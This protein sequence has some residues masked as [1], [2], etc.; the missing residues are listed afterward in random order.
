M[1]GFM[2]AP[3]ILKLLIIILVISLFTQPKEASAISIGSNLRNAPNAFWG[4]ELAPIFNPI[5]GQPQLAA[6]G[7]T[8]CTFRNAGYMGSLQ[9]GSFV[10]SNGFITEVRVR[11]GSNPA[12]LRVVIMQCSPGLCGTAVRFSRVFRPK[13]NGITVFQTLLKVSRSSTTGNN[14]LQNITD[15]VGISAVGPGTLPLRDEGTA[16]TFSQGS[17]FTQQW[18]PAL[19]RNVPRVAD[20]TTVDGLEVTMRARFQRTAPSIN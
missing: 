4:C 6:T 12:P 19:T 7:Q 13:A 10:P 3:W 17:A 14:G 20:A 9:L 16:G 1:R 2:K 5:T 11:S 18:Y 15:A 8:S